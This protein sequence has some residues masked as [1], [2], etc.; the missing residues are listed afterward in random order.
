MLI[1]SLEPNWTLQSFLDLSVSHMPPV[2]QE[3]RG[4]IAV[5]GAMRRDG[6]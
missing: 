5:F 2:A 6:S 4:E 1:H 3:V